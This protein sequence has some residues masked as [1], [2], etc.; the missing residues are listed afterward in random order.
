ME[1]RERDK[2]ES[3][4]EKR[5][6]RRRRQLYGDVRWHKCLHVYEA[7]LR[8]LAVSLQKKKTL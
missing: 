2:R 4:E 8:N 5:P 3:L 1:D 6:E 7:E